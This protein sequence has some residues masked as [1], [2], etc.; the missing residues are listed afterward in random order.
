M[1]NHERAINEGVEMIKDDT[2]AKPASKAQEVATEFAQEI[3]KQQ[4]EGDYEKAVNEVMVDSKLSTDTKEGKEIFDWLMSEKDGNI[5]MTMDKMG[6]EDIK[7][8][9]AEATLIEVM[10]KRVPDHEMTQA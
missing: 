4:L 2:G 10:S 6:F 8:A 5:K 9:E 1:F 3:I 7:P